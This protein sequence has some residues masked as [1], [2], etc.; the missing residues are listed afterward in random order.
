M[1]NYIE[2]RDQVAFHPGYYIKEIIEEC[3]LS[4]EDF[5]KRLNTTPKNLSLLVRGEQSLSVDI[6]V[7]LSRML[8]TSTE[9]WLNLQNAFDCFLTDIRYEKE[10]ELEKQILK[11]LGYKY[12]RDFYMLPNLPRKMEEQ[13]KQVRQFLKVATL[14]VLKEPDVAVNFRS[15][16]GFSED[17]L[18]RANAM[19]QI[20]IN[21]AAEYKAPKYDKKKFRE[22]AARAIALTSKHDGF[23]QTLHQDFLQAGVILEVLPNIQGS[24]VNGASKKVGSNVMLM[25]SDRRLYSDTFW[26]TLYH[27]IGHILNGDYGA[28][29]ED[30][31]GKEKV[32]EDLADQYAAEM[33][34][35]A[36][37][38][39]DFLRKN[40]FSEKAIRDFA[41][42]INRDPGIVYGRLTYEGLISYADQRL[43]TLRYK[44]Y[45]NAL[46]G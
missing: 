31:E 12:F 8:G 3:G 36:E 2:Y 30:V 18:I 16:T 13:V 45:I 6:A 17:N 32:R 11:C 25:I 46:E 23:Y 10:L 29:V 20:A 43:R 38:Y 7:K 9:Y 14:S 33:L 42:S 19:V 37:K 35:P 27:E 39:S 24:K 4:Q 34:I 44:Y 5:A 41:S 40:D 28:T 1:S 15:S 26:F 21:R 22:A